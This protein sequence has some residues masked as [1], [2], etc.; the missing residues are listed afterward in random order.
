MMTRDGRGARKTPF[1][2]IA[3]RAPPATI[4]EDTRLVSSESDPGPAGRDIIFQTSDGAK[5]E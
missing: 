4:S 2:A 5:L 3:D 1:S